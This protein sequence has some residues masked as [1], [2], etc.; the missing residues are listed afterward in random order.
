MPQSRKPGFSKTGLTAALIGAGIDYQHVR[1]LG[2]PKEGRIAARH[3]DA[4]TLRRVYTE[5]LEDDAAQAALAALVER[6]RVQPTCL[7]CFERDYRGCH[8]AIVAERVAGATGFATIHLLP[9]LPAG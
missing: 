2:T 9:G 4:A 6:A 3:G 7:L 8:R 5:H 1:A